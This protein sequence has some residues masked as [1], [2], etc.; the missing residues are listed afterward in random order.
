MLD[1]TPVTTAI[2][3]MIVAGTPPQQLITAVT[4]AFPNLTSRE[5]SQAIQYAT[6]AAERRAARKH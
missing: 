2:A 5:L 3:A 1:T 6:A 4:T